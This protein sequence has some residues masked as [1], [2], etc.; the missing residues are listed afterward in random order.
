[1]HDREGMSIRRNRMKSASTAWQNS[2]PELR[3]AM[4]P[5]SFNTWIE[6]MASICIKDNT[7]VLQ[8][9]DEASKSTLKNIYRDIITDCVNRANGSAYAVKFIDEGEL[10][11]YSALREDRAVYSSDFNLD[12]KY[13]FESFVVGNGNNL[14][15][16]AAKAV[17]E[18]FTQAYNPLFIYGGVGLGKTHLLHA[19]G[20]RMLE[21][22]PRAKIVYITSET[23]TNDLIQSIQDKTNVQFRNKYRTMDL[24]MIDDIQFL[25]GRDRTQEE[26]YNTFN[27]VRGANKQIIITSDKPP[28]EL[29]NLESRLVSRFEGGLVADIQPPDLETRCAILK[30]R[31]IMENVDIDESVVTF[32]AERV[33]S[34]IRQLEGAFTRVV[35]YA[36]LSRLPLNVATADAALKDIIP[37]YD[38]TRITVGFIQQIVV[39][40]YDVELDALLSS[41][42]SKDITYP[43]Q[44][45][46]YLCKNLTTET[47]NSIGSAFGGRHYST[48]IDACNKIEEDSRTN[49]QLS[50]EIEDLTKRIKVAKRN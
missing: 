30:R 27:A 47:F 38:N 44:V 37:G 34:N 20:H 46:M 19:I 7:L 28:K 18:S 45:A 13:T 40:F 21:K 24:L 23:F 41:R 31:S 22:N 50:F 5:I 17:A 25:T 35:A 9:K 32:I 1:M 10:P 16:A 2:L 42:R 6:P 33:Y 48:V 39:D 11:L 15:H 12:P 36:S 3:A 29:F 43:R 14:S 8:A 49:R 4:T 26:F